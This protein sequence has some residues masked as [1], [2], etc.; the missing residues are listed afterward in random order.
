MPQ[1][2][3]N[4]SFIPHMATIFLVNDHSQL[5]YYLNQISMWPY[6]FEEDPAQKTIIDDA[7]NIYAGFCLSGG[8]S[9]QCFDL[10]V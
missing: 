2:H 8:L 7:T 5:F 3:F 10:Q 9:P 6:C 4:L 1:N